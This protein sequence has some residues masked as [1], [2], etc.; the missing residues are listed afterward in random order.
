LLPSITRAQGFGQ[1]SGMAFDVGTSAAAVAYSPDGRLLA[2]ASPGGL[3]CLWDVVTGA[4]LT[5]IA[6][7]KGDNGAIRFSSD[8]KSLLSMGEGNVIQSW[9]VSQLR[10]SSQSSSGEIAPSALADLWDDLRGEDRVALYDAIR[11]LAAGSKQSLPLLRE[12]LHAV[13]AV[14]TQRINQLVTELEKEDFN[15]RKKAAVELRKLGDLAIPALQQ[16]AEKNYDEVLRSFLS[17]LQAQY[18][19]PEQVQSAYAVQVLERIGNDDARKLLDELAKGASESML[20]RQATQAV[21][22]LS[23]ASPSAGPEQK[24]E[25]L[26][27]DLGSDDGKKAFRAV[28]ALAQRPKEALPLVTKQLQALAVLDDSTERIAKLIGELDS[29]DFAVRDRAAKELGKIGR[30]AE[31][32]LRKALASSPSVEAKQRLETLLRSA[33]ADAP[34]AERLQAERAIESLEWAASDDVR[35][36]LDQLGKDSKNR[37]LKD[38]VADSLKRMGK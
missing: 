21:E 15:G 18:P 34:S 1:G 5:P 32:A 22:H 14:D 6:G 16:A 31:G 2:V 19:T 37:W 17:K 8:G 28:R 33:V 29:D 20:T 12:K 24:L 13:P 4:E 27:N 25:T 7:D 36:F 10:R 26:W 9:P 38:A 23:K 30:S 35:K 3:V 11:T